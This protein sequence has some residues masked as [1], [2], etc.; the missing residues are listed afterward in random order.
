M[1]LSFE[2]SAAN[3]NTSRS[4]R[5]AHPVYPITARQSLTNLLSGLPLLGSLFSIPSHH[6]WL[7]F[8]SWAE[9]YGPLYLI[10]IAGRHH[11]IVS[12]E[13]IANDLLR[14]RGTLY[15]SRE[16]LPMA[17]K[18]VSGNLRP[19][20]LPYNATW[21]N[22]RKLMQALTNPTVTAS[23]AD[24]QLLEST[25]LLHALVLQPQNYERWLERYAAGVI[26]RLAYGKRVLTGEESY[27][28]RILNVVHTIERV[29]SPGAYLVDTFPSLMHL[30][31]A[32]APFKREGKRLHAEELCLFRDLQTSVIDGMAAGTA[33]PSFMRT[34]LANPKSYGLSDDQAAYVIGT[35]FEAGAGTTAAT[36]MSFLLALVMHP[37]WQ[38]KLHL[39]VDA[40]V[41]PTR[42]PTFEDIPQLPLARA[43]A[44]ET[45]RWRPVTAGGLPHQLTKD[46]VYDGFFLPAGTIVHPNQWAIH[47][48]AA[49]YPDPETFNPDRWLDPSF[50]TYKEP[51]SKYPNLQGFSAFGFGRRICPGLNIAERS[52]FLLVARLGWAVDVRKKEGVKV[53]EYE[54][55]TGFNVQ[56]RFFDFDLRARGEA[57]WNVV[58]D[59]LRKELERDPLREV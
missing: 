15:S 55:T 31:I 19:V 25:R 56:P 7:K 28:Q 48:E 45:L 17:A 49:L 29:A 9:T 52:L 20:F 10:N 39:A 44:K 21:R 53:K 5:Y 40:V 2:T 24:V 8:A 33:P 4:Q 41:P 46:D 59:E 43:M 30:P 38:Q 12:T 36:M 6:S 13:K 32:L 51:L 26:L 3:Q 50:P 37:E 34:Y 57:R 16:Q 54:Y 35:L 11:I 58:E 42:I 1:A 23:Y 18:L 14:E 27:V 22:G 47:R